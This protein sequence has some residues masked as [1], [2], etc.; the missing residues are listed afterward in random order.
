MTEGIE[1][2]PCQRR[3]CSLPFPRFTYWADSYCLEKA[4]QHKMHERH[5]RHEHATWAALLVVAAEIVAMQV[6]NL[7]ASLEDMTKLGSL[8]CGECE[9]SF[10]QHHLHVAR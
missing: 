4:S 2:L 1:Y 8:G 10:S 5:E 3:D 7:E 9:R 6:H